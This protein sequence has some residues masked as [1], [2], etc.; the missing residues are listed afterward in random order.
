MPS[1]SIKYGSNTQKIDLDGK[2]RH[3]LIITKYLYLEEQ[4]IFLY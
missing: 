1:V 2:L 4:N 3:S